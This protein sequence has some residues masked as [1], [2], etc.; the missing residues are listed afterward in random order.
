MSIITEA[1]KKLEK[2]R[3]LSSGEYLNKILGPERKSSF[4][5]DTF[6]T[7]K[8][9]AEKDIS[10]AEDSKVSNA[11]YRIR[12][13]TLVISGILLLLTIVFLTATNIFLIPSLNVEVARSERP[14]G[15][16]VEAPVAEAYTNVKPEVALVEHKT[17]LINRMTRVLKGSSI[18][19]EFMSNFK[20]SGIV[21]D[22]DDSWAIVNDKVVRVGDYLDGATIVSVAPGKV[23]LRYKDERFALAVE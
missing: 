2:N 21:Y 22:M 13:K 11:V 16:I 1:L 4:K 12:S 23:V 3:T 15:S 5:K 14:A 17:D 6:K 7:E 18:Q 19:D 9:S 10:S 8:P 20:L